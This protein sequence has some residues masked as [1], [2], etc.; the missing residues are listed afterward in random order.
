MLKR[1]ELT[2]QE[3]ERIVH[4]FPPEYTGKHGRSCKDKHIMFNAVV[5]DY[6]ARKNGFP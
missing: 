6:S 3:W 4:L 1:Y 2:D 5:L